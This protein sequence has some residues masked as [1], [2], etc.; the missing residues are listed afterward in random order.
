M[1]KGACFSKL[2]FFHL[3]FGLLL[4]ICLHKNQGSFL[5]HVKSQK[6]IKLREKRLNKLGKFVLKGAKKI[7]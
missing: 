2:N 6:H 1:D 3:K 4:N 7:L 5:A